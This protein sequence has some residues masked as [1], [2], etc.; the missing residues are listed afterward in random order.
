MEVPVVAKISVRRK[1]KKKA[2]A[3]QSVW[4]RLV[5]NTLVELCAHFQPKIKLE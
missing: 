5:R 3:T 4:A 1:K 2:V